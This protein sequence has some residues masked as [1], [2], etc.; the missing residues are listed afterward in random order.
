[1]KDWQYIGIGP[2]KTLARRG[3]VGY[4]VENADVKNTGKT[5]LPIMPSTSNQIGQ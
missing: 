2:I 1:M 3:L 4:N 5:T